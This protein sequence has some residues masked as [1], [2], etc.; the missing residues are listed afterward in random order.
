MKRIGAIISNEATGGTLLLLATAAALIAENSGF[1]ELYH[2]FLHLEFTFGMGH[3]NEV[4]KLDMHHAIND[5]LMAVFFLLVGIEI[6][7]EILEGH[8]KSLPA[9]AMPGIAALAGMGV[10][11]AIYIAF[12]LDNPTALSGWAIPSATDIA[13]A[14]G[15]LALLGKLVPYPLKIFLLTV[16]VLDDLGAILVIAFFYTSDLRLDMLGLSALCLLVLWVFNWLGVYRRSP[17]LLVGALMW[18]FVLMSGVHATIAGVLLAFTLPTRVLHSTRKFTFIGLE[19]NEYYGNE[20]PAARMEHSLAG[21]VTFF[22]LPLFAFTNA[23]VPL[24]GMGLGDLSGVAFGV[25]GGLLIGKAIGIFIAC[26]LMFHT[27]FA[28]MPEGVEMGDYFGVAILCGIG[29]TMSLFITGLSFDSIELT[30]QARIG[31]LSGSTLAALA[32]FAYLN[33]NLRRR[34]AQPAKA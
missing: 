24:S 22:I 21:W 16:A 13:F 11:A 14:V 5:L 31:I 3:G 27:G 12:N 1:K 33:F 32:G 34:Q 19:L 25:A 18:Y 7:R 6:K 15:V 30:N 26:W 17:Y 4:L 20:A 29:F 28:R 10:P 2:H 9:I 8:L 23:G